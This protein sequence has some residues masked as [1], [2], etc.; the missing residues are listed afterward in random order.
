MTDLDVVRLSQNPLGQVA[1][2]GERGD[3]VRVSD[4]TTS[5]YLF[6]WEFEATSED[7]LR[8][9]LAQRAMSLPRPRLPAAGVVV[10]SR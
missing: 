9:L 5:Q 2:P 7:E 10:P 4:A 1:P 6:P 3:L 8:W